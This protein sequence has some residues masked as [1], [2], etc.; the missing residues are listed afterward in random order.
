MLRFSAIT[1]IRLKEQNNM[2]KSGV[3]ELKYVGNW[4]TVC[5]Q[6]NR[7]SWNMRAATVACRQLHYEGGWPLSF[8]KTPEST[9]HLCQFDCVG[10]KIINYYISK[11]ILKLNKY[12]K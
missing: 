5:K 10:G 4:L 6:S 3:V 7:D 11:K 2:N 12:L 9:I 8:N 1:D